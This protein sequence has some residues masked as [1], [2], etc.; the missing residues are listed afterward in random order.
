MG[1]A[2]AESGPA[3]SATATIAAR[4]RAHR[5]PLRPPHHTMCG[6]SPTAF[7]QASSIAQPA[8]RVKKKSQQAGLLGGAPER[9]RVGMPGDPATH[10]RCCGVLRIGD[11]PRCR[12]VILWSSTEVGQILGVLGEVSVQDVAG[13][14]K[15][16]DAGIEQEGLECRLPIAGDGGVH[17]K[18]G[19][20]NLATA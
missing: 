1:F 20:R 11:G 5:M 6:R 18:A 13:G 4:M 17:G 2:L 9:S 10:L 16:I 3:A 12:G 8:G 14:T 15:I 7:P 19:N